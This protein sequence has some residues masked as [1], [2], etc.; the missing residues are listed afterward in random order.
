MH[1]I[2][3]IQDKETKGDITNNILR[4][5][6]EWF[7]IEEAIVNY[8]QTVKETIFYAAYVDESPVG[9]IG[10]KSNSKYTAEVYVMGVLKEHHRKGIGKALMTEAERIIKE[11]TFKFLMVKTLS[12]SHPDVHYAKTRELYSATG[13]YPLEEIIEIWGDENPCLLMVKKL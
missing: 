10:I 9:F 13:F 3:Q 12:D 6:P 11:S 8:I 4:N 5:L 2:V 7:G 1:T